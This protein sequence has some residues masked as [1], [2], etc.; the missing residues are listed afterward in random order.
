MRGRERA[1]AYRELP[2]RDFVRLKTDTMS[3]VVDNPHYSFH[4]A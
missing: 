1:C 4:Y 3:I 2:V